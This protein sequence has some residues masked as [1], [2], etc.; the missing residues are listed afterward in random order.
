MLR[1]LNRLVRNSIADAILC[2][3][4]ISPP[5]YFITILKY[6]RLDHGLGEWLNTNAHQLLTCLNSW[7]WK[8]YVVQLHTKP[9][10]R[11]R[12]FQKCLWINICKSHLQSKPKYSDAQHTHIYTHSIIL[13]NKMFIYINDTMIQEWQRC[14]IQKVISILGS[15]LWMEDKKA[16]P[17]RF[18]RSNP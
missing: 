5:A 17:A 18:S 7:Q 9:K 12:L 8:H 4:F 3:E 16:Q 11:Q 6:K 13:G 10:N 14:C 15:L 1:H 2:I